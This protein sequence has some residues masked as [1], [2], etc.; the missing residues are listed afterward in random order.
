MNYKEILHKHSDDS[1]CIRCIP[2]N[3][4]KL[5]LLSQQIIKH[6]VDYLYIH[7]LSKMWICSTSNRNL[8]FKIELFWEE[9]CFNYAIEKVVGER[10]K[11]LKRSRDFRFTF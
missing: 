1:L 7:Y 10:I 8:S 9:Q 11:E 6:Q 5:F 4:E 3:N 2:R